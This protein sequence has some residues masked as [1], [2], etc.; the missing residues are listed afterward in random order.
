MEI[1]VF[2]YRGRSLLSES[3]LHRIPRMALKQLPVVQPGAV[4]GSSDVEPLYVLADPKEP[5]RR[6]RVRSFS[7]HQLDKTVM[8]SSDVLWGGQG[9]TFLMHY[10]SEESKQIGLQDVF[11]RESKLVS[12]PHFLMEKLEAKVKTEQQDDDDNDDALPNPVAEADVKLVGPAAQLEEQEQ[13]HTPAKAPR[14]LPKGGKSPASYGPSLRRASSR[15]SV[16]DEVPDPE[17]VYGEGDAASESHTAGGVSA[18][19]S[20]QEKSGCQYFYMVWGRVLIW[21]RR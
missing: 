4:A 8:S 15:M 3:G 7:G 9:H 20:K 18:A 5:Y 21:H 16:G 1:V 12:W 17:D 11:A 19:P 14:P 2:C 10:D 6:L 13:R